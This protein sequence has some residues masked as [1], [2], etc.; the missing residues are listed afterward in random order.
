MYLTRNH[1]RDLEAKLVED[2]HDGMHG[3]RD[4]NW[5]CSIVARLGFSVSGFGLRV[6]GL[7]FRV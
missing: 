1:V 6:E 3:N 5:R 2:H 7:G 4:D